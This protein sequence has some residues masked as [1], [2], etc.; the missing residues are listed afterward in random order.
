[1]NVREKN[2]GQVVGNLRVDA[3]GP[4]FTVAG[5]VQTQHFNAGPL[6][7]GTMFKTDVTGHATMNLALPA[8][9]RPLRGTYAVN[10][11]RANVIGYEVRDIASRG[12]INWPTI[13]VDGHASAYGGRATAKGTIEATSPLRLDL[14]GKA[15]RVDLRNLP[16]QLNVPG[17][18]SNLQFSYTLTGRGPVL[19][20]DV[21]ME[22]STI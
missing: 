11:T 9:G 6:V 21:Q 12:R 8:N 7:R 14:T 4:Q 3:L 17:V 10:A 5:E 13:T 20:G 19:S 15:A 1:L 18:P 16:P 22:E 2:V